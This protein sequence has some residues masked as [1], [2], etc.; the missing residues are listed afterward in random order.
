LAGFKKYAGLFGVNDEKGL[1]LAELFGHEGGGHGVFA[2]NNAGQAVTIQKLINE[3]VD[4]VN[5]AHYPF[6]PDVL[7]KV[8]DKDKALEPT[9]RYAQQV[10]QQI[11]KELQPP[12]K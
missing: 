5:S 6:P 12:K 4:A 3:A 9:E 11:N 8:A 10:E 7:Q 2:I 1:R